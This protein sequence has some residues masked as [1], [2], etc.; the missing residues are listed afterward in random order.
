M[1]FATIYAAESA[2][3]Y[4]K[5]PKLAKIHPKT[6]NLRNFEMPPKIN[7]SVSQK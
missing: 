5:L 7:I 1:L 4:S 6:I 2:Q 3:I